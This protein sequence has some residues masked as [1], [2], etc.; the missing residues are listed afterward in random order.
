MSNHTRR[1]NRMYP[2]PGTATMAAR[3]AEIVITWHVG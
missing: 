1:R 2:A 3:E